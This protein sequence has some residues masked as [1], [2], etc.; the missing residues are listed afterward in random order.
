VSEVSAPNLYAY[1]DK[2]RTRADTWLTLFTDE[3][4][5]DGLRLLAEAAEKEPSGPVV[6]RLD[7]LVLEWPCHGVHEVLGRH[8]NVQGR[9][10]TR[11]PVDIPEGYLTE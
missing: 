8:A 10:C 5:E 1:C 2:I 6:S 3:E 4:F 7:L 9:F 11:C